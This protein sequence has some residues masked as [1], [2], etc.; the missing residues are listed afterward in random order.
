[1]VQKQHI[2]LVAVL[3][4]HLFE[5]TIL[6]NRHILTPIIT[7]H[8]RLIKYWHGQELF[9]LLPFMKSWYC[10]FFIISLVC[11]C[12]AIFHDLVTQSKRNLPHYNSLQSKFSKKTVNLMINKKVMSYVNA[13]LTFKSCLSF[14]S[15]PIWAFVTN[16]LIL[17]TYLHRKVSL[18]HSYLFLI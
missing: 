2:Y 14:L 4:F 17:P 7:R 10:Y 9:K 5:T 18:I 15:R 6:Q 11:L 13:Q 1:M 8:K 16:K 12:N 3:F